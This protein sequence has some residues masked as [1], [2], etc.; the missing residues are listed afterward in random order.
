LIEDACPANYPY[1]AHDAYYATGFA[2]EGWLCDFVG[3]FSTAVALEPVCTF[4][5]IK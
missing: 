3:A 5:D 4:R 2:A 1:D